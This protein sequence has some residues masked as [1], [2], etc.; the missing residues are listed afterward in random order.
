MSR[1]QVGDLGH[2]FGTDHSVEG[3]S[4]TGANAPRCLSNSANAWRNAE[5]RHH[6]HTVAFYEKHLTE[7]GLA[8]AQGVRQHGLKHRLQVRPASWR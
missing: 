1:R 5:M 3:C 8:D 7:L 6:A 4:G 2:L